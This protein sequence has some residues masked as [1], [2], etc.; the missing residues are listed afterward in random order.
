TSA[1]STRRA[2]GVV[3]RARPEWTLAVHTAG[4]APKTVRPGQSTTMTVEVTNRGPS[5][6][7]NAV[8]VVNAP[9]ST[10][11][12]RL[13]AATAQF[14]TRVSSGSVRCILDLAAGPD[15]LQLVVPIIIDAKAH[16]SG[17]LDG[18]CVDLDGAA[19]CGTGD[20]PIDPIVLKAM[21][22]AHVASTTP[23]FG[24]PSRVG[25]G[26]GSSV[27]TVGGSGVGT[28]GGTA[29]RGGPTSVAPS[30][31]TPNDNS[32][33]GGD[34]TDNEAGGGADNTAAGSLPD[35]GQDLSGVLVLSVMLV[36]GGVAALLVARNRPRRRPA[37]GSF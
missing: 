1:D 32:D 18:G 25:T 34:G 9:K 6:A 28:V 36:V 12:D 17:T 23:G 15:T 5:D 11:F 3:V 21:P 2:T 10:T 26:G 31:T 13:P 35:A 20:D 24:P 7:E 8:V 22:D 16:S 30:A 27:S 29:Q 4:P 14:C 19:G 37:A 33:N